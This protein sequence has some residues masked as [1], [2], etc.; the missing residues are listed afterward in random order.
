MKRARFG[1]KVVSE[2]VRGI[3]KKYLKRERERRKKVQRVGRG[4]QR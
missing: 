4:G 2:G 1:L 3:F